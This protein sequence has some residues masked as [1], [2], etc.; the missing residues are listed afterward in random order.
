MFAY[1]PVTKSFYDNLIK[2]AHA[3]QKYGDRP[4]TK[5]LRDVLQVWHAMFEP[6]VGFQDASKVDID[7]AIA[8]CDAAEYACLGHDY[9]EDCEGASVE[10]LREHGCPEDAIHAIVLVTKVP[11]NVVNAYK[12]YLSDIAEDRLAFEVKVSDSYSN[13]NCSIKDGNFKR[14]QRYSNQINLLYKYREEFLAKENK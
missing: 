12:V 7:S 5:H 3:G 14:V 9:L 11:R 6:R 10:K 1:E 2:P 13:M 8:W 4:Y